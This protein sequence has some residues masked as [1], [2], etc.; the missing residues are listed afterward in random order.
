MT[1]AL[2][3][4]AAKAGTFRSPGGSA[5]HIAALADFGLA[6]MDLSTIKVSK[7]TPEA[8]QRCMREGLCLRC[9]EKSHLAKDCPKDQRN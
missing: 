3:I 9:R 8:R 6:P 1:D 7:L 5:S 4:E 2:R